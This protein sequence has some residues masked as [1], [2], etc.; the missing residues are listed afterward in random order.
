[1]R[2]CAAAVLMLSALGACAESESTPAPEAAFSAIYSETDAADVYVVAGEHSPADDGKILAGEK[3]DFWWVRIE[4]PKK[5]GASVDVSEGAMFD[6]V[7]SDTALVFSHNYL[8]LCDPS[9]NATTSCWLLE[10]YTVGDE[11]LSGR[12][13]VQREVDTVSMQYRV[14]W[15]GITDRFEGPPQWHRHI[16]NGQVAAAIEGE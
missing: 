9:S 5:G 4:V 16:T 12:I 10:R 8:D 6:L 7:T 13:R 15:E 2:N 11:G 14:E 1:M 3:T